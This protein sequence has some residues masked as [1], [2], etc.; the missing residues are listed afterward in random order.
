MATSFPDWF[1]QGMPDRDG[2]VLG[3]LLDGGN[4]DH[5]DRVFALFENGASWSYADTWRNTRSW[6]RGLQQLGVK[7]GDA[8]SVWLPNRP[9]ILSAWFGANYIG[10]TY[11]PINTAYRGDLLSHVIHNAGAKI[12]I[13]HSELLPR[14]TNADLA[15][16]EQI[17][18]VGDLPDI[19]LGVPIHSA[20]ILNGDPDSLEEVPDVMPWDTM[21]IIYTSGTTGPS[22]GVRCSYFHFYNVGMLAV[23]FIKTDERCFVNMPL[24]HIGAAGGTF[25][26]LASH[27]SIG[28]VDG[29]ST[30][31]FWDQI[32]SMDC[33][34]MCGLVGSTVAFLSKREPAD[35]DKDNPLRRV[36]VAPVNE[37]V[38]A[39][40]K[41]HDFGYFTGFG[42]TEAPMPL[43]SEVDTTISGGYCG[44]PRDGVECR[45]VDGN[46]IEVAAGITGELI[47]RSDHPW[48]MNHGY[49]NMPEATV[50]AWRNGWFHT[51][52]AFRCDEEGN[53]YF[54]DR[55]KD[56]IRRRGENISS[57]EVEKV[58]LEYPQ[59]L[60]VAAIPVPAEHDEDEVMIVIEP[61]PGDTID[62]VALTEFLVERMAHFM[63]P[64][65]IRM[66]PS[67][68]KT[69]TNKV[70]KPL[71]KSEGVTE[72][73]WDREAAGIV[74]RR[75]RLD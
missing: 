59:V 2:C 12:L 72:D 13:G 28:V 19:D 70:Q 54:V 57:L 10:A 35:N 73:T 43:I 18:C 45:V 68:P 48:S 63:V 46:D 32:R 75:I 31:K 22:K 21:A 53:F 34:V 58:V 1:Q 4:R 37:Q 26:A 50:A 60:D 56:A 71:L 44:R 69:P 55:L 20:D 24:F 25:G 62:P 38:I 8:V 36:I 5:P 65:Y 6:A 39:L 30:S 14:L 27:A 47:V 23:G 64:R 61:Q 41:R 7:A 9:E 67:L 49:I 66:M 29:F 17:I 42:M 11:A 3:P 51:G 33:A 40:A 52:D 15:Q 74:L 16:I